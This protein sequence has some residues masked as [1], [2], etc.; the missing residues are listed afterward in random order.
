MTKLTDEEVG[1][2]LRETFADKEN[3]VDSLPVATRRRK[4]PVLLAAAAVLVLLA[5]VL[6]AAGDRDDKIAAEGPRD[7]AIWATVISE[8][9]K[10]TPE[11]KVGP[12]LF[13]LAA[14]Q[15]FPPPGQ[16]G[17]V[18]GPDFSTQ[19]KA[20]IE[21]LVALG[22]P[23]RWTDQVH[24][25]C[26]SPLPGS[27]FIAVGL[28]VDKGDHQEVMTYDARG[29]MYATWATYRVVQDGKSWKVDG[30]VKMSGMAPADQPATPTA[31]R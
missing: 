2:L 21:Q 8:M 3:L 7:A 20:R 5:G 1:R 29:C 13:I 19:T 17:H 22:R 18:R 30:P 26:A 10:K 27:R 31:T 24:S 23:V 14:P 25:S 9:M 28:I 16:S 12:D 15:N 6:F 11:E 4:A